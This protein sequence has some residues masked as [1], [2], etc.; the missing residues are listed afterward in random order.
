MRQT[1]LTNAVEYLYEQT[2]IST[3]ADRA[4]YE[5][6]FELLD[7]LEMLLFTCSASF[8]IQWPFGS[9]DLSMFVAPC[10]KCPDPA[11]AVVKG[12]LYCDK[13]GEVEFKNAPRKELENK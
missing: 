8:F 5:E 1:P 12:I 3:G 4:Y 9:H 13:H 11:T 2:E 7:H 10:S 6:G